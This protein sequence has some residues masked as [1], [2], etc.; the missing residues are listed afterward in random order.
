MAEDA[1]TH[2]GFSEHHLDHPL[3]SDM[4]R[5]AIAFFKAELNSGPMQQSVGLRLKCYAFLCTVMASNNMLQHTNPVEK[6][7]VKGVKRGMKS[8]RLHFEY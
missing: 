6:K 7:T 5:K 8:A 2:Y 4:N 1:A 3:Y